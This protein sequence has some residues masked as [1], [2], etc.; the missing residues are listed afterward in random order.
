[1][2][3]YRYRLRFVFHFPA[4][5]N[6]PM[7]QIELAAQ[8]HDKTLSYSCTAHGLLFFNHLIKNL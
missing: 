1:M 4:A 8:L 3:K 5:V 6:K 7:T 2:P